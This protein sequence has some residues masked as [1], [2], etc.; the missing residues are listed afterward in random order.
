M[1]NPAPTLECRLLAACGCAYSIDDNGGFIPPQPYF[2]ASGFQPAPKVIVGGPDNI[3][4][5]LVGQTG[6]GAVLAFRGTLPPDIHDL[7]SLLDWMQDFDAVPISVAGMP[8]QVHAG[9]WR[10]L[11][12]IWEQ[13]LAAV[14]QFRAG[15]GANVPLYVTGHSKGGGLAHLAAMRF[16]AQGINPTEVFT[17]AAPRAGN[18]AFADAYNAAI[19]AFRYEYT[20]DIVPHLPPS[21]ML[22]NALAHIPLLG[23]RFAGVPAWDYADVGTLRFI[24]WANQIVGD[25]ELLVA[26]RI[27]HLSLLIAEFKFNQIAGD[28]DHSCGAGYMSVVCPGTCSSN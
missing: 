19:S 27:A 23:Q 21:L 25:S 7:A 6:D 10:G 8:G 18:P 12:T 16:R 1:A 26:Q 3:N 11:D 13:I 14:A 15:A 4:A 5:C 20:D 28:H 24:N 22:V 2:D 9:F 17:Y